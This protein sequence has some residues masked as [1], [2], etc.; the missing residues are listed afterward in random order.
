MLDAIAGAVRDLGEQD[1]LR[2]L[3]IT[4]EGRCFTSGLDMNSLRGD[5]G[6]GSDGTVRGSNIRRQYRAHARHDLWDEM[7]QVEKPIVLA[8]QAHCFGLGV[9]MAVSC[10][11][12]LASE[13]ATS[14]GRAATRGDGHGQAGHRRGRRGRPEN[15]P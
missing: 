10:D 9:E 2:V 7:E 15:G 8:A 11:F 3:V 1:D 14:A 12:R 5:V 4:G 6:R 13:D